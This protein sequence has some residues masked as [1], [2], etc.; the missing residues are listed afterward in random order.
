MFVS[1]LHKQD[2]KFQIIYTK[3]FGEDSARLE[4]RCAVNPL[5]YSVQHELY[6]DNKCVKNLL[7]YISE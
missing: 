1:I 5:L 2:I 4:K 3:C 7:S 6:Q